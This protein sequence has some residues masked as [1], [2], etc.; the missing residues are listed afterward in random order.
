MDFSERLNLYMAEI[1]CNAKRLS[2][3]SGI[4]TAAISR[5]RK[6]ER[7]PDPDGRQLHLLADGI[8]N[9][10]NGSLD[11][12]H[13]HEELAIAI[14]GIAVDYGTFLANLGALLEAL[15]ANNNEIARALSFDPSYISRILAGQRRPADMRAFVA[16]VAGFASRRYAQKQPTGKMLE[17]A[18][19]NW[20][21]ISDDDERAKA[22]ADWLGTNYL[23]PSNPVGSFLGKLDAFNLDDF[24]RTVRFDGAALPPMLDP[25]PS[26]R[27]YEGIR[28]MMACELDFLQATLQSKSSADVIMYSEMPLLDMATD[29]E[30]PRA[31][32]SGMAMVLQKG[33]RFHVIH[34]TNRPL[35]EMM[36]GLESWIPMYM[37]G[38]IM[39]YYLEPVPTSPFLHLLKASG[40]V[41]VQGEAVAGYQAEGRYVLAYSRDEVRYYRRRAERLLERARPLMHIVTKAN[42]EKLAD[43][44]DADVPDGARLRIIMS[45]LPLATIPP[46]LLE[47]MLERNG[48][49]EAERQAVRELAQ[50]KAAR[51]DDLASRCEI[52]LDVPDFPPEEFEVHAP[53]LEL[54]DL[55]PEAAVPYSR[56]EYAEHL[57]ALRRSAA[58][59][60]NC[61]IEMDRRPAFRNVQ[62]LVHEGRRVVVSKN[63]SP[64]IHFIIE[65]PDMV[66]A[67]ERFSTDAPDVA[68]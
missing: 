63:A 67:F 29:P 4:S 54:A 1:G 9:L 62:I 59:R 12:R 61:T 11:A 32:M 34:D 10:S 8:A 26:T 36:L 21:D 48:V 31:W 45:T 40:S 65:H 23:P 39:P 28:E 14:S 56:E 35:P 37:T 60:P 22:I 58:E 53:A 30:F 25:P 51:F 68:L 33:L 20:A 19:A 42:A 2:E 15:P 46:E 3:S 18:N 49:G 43:F 16:G 66:A 7:I 27:T 50:L 13:V 5:Y 47:R 38:Q 17:L 55:F 24:I 44:R 64:V 57:A 52:V 41:A 6:G